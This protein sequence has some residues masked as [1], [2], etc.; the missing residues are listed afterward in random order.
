MLYGALVVT[1]WTCYGALEIIVLLLLLLLLMTKQT[2]GRGSWWDCRL[3][4]IRQHVLRD[5]GRGVLASKI[6]SVQV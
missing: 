5:A 1:L 3:A 2:C 6:V 4:T